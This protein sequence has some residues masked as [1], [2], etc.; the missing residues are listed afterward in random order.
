MKT[1]ISEDQAYRE[2]S[3]SFQKGGKQK[4]KQT[5]R[6]PAKQWEPNHIRGQ[7][8]GP[9]HVLKADDFQVGPRAGQ[10]EHAFRT[11]Q[12]LPCACISPGLGAFLMMCFR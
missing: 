9:F 11:A 5:Q 4:T 12:S 8:S 1:K 3:K 10:N 2:D 6:S 7:Q